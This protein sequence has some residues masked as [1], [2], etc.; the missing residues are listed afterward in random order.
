MT[1]TRRHD[2]ARASEVGGGEGREQLERDREL[3]EILSELRVVLPGVTVLFAFLLTVPF[4]GKFPEIDT[5]DRAAY[6]LAFI[7]AAVSMVFLV[8]ESA[9]HRIVGK[10]YDKARLTRTASRQAV[11]GIAALAVALTAVVFLVGD[12][13]YGSKVAA[14]VATSVLAL[15]LGVWFVFPLTRRDRGRS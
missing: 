1:T 9:Y 7:S 3:D 4:T 6:F 11:V 8:G 12:V 15:A 2:G 5:A 10:P 14:G 13:V